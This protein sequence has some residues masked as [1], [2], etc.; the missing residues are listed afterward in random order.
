MDNKRFRL[1]K[2]KNVNDNNLIIFDKNNRHQTRPLQWTSLLIDKLNYK[3]NVK[4]VIVCNT[5]L[6]K[7][8][9][10]LANVSKTNCESI[11][12]VSLRSSMLSVTTPATL[13]K[14]YSIK[15]GFGKT[16]KQLYF[17]DRVNI[18]RKTNDWTEYL[19]MSWSGLHRINY[20]CGKALEAHLKRPVAI[21]NCVHLNVCQNNDKGS[22]NKIL[23]V[24]KFYNITR[25]NN[26]LIHS[27]GQLNKTIVAEMFNVN[28]F[29]KLFVKGKAVEMIVGAKIDGIIEGKRA[30]PIET[31]HNK[32]VNECTFSLSI[33]PIVFFNIE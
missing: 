3:D 30:H 24:R 1:D 23:F 27:T 7:L 26:Q 9:D 11:M 21:Q 20:L 12:D 2:I 33:K 22:V 31:V 4:N 18:V 5:F 32:I 16:A 25:A 19:T 14:L 10:E 13:R 29:E 8:A 17:F 6:N 28:Q 15:K